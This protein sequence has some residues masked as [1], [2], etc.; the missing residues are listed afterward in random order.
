MLTNVKYS[1]TDKSIGPILHL[2]CIKM[3]LEAIPTRVQSL[4]KFHPSKLWKLQGSPGTRC[5]HG[6][7]KQQ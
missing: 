1:D 2:F 7:G 6:D 3:F 5:C 4:K